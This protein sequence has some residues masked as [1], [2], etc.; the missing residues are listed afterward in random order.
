MWYVETV[1]TSCPCA[2]LSWIALAV[3]AITT[4]CGARVVVQDFVPQDCRARPSRPDLPADSCCRHGAGDVFTEA[5]MPDSTT[6]VR[7]HVA[8]SE[9]E[10]WLL[11]RGRDRSR[12]LMA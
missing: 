8:T 9:Y 3:A 6:G 4:G 2:G 1:S 10:V 11:S 7:P 5:L 12:V